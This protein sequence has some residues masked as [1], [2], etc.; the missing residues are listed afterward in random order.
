M[1]ADL[2]MLREDPRL[3]QPAHQMRS[4]HTAPQWSGGRDSLTKG[5]IVESKE[6]RSIAGLT[7]A[8]VEAISSRRSQQFGLRLLRYCYVLVSQGKVG[9]EVRERVDGSSEDKSAHSQ[10]ARRGGWRR[11]CGAYPLRRAEE[12]RA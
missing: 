4:V 6:V 7:G 8:A 1:S 11:T 2:L 12:K 9:P 10:R 3:R 5:P